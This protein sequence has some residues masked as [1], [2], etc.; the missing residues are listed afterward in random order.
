MKELN[1][2]EKQISNSPTTAAWENLTGSLPLRMTSDYLFKFLLQSDQDVLKAL[3]CAYLDLAPDEVVSICVTNTISLADDPQKKEMI[4]DIKAEMNDDTIINLEMQVI[5]NHDWPERS[6]TYLCR[7]FDNL[8][9]GQAYHRVKGAIHI[10]F[11]DYTLFPEYPEFYSRYR[12]RNE[13]TG[14]LYSS[15]FLISVVNLTK[16]E[17]ATEE[18][19]QAHRD[20]WASF[21]KATS[22]EELKM[23]AQQDTDIAKAVT[24]VHRLF[25]DE[26]FRQQYEAHE[27]RIRQQLDHD[28]WYDNEIKKREAEIADKD[29]EIAD[30]DAEIADK[31]AEIADKDAA[32]ADKDAAIA[33]KDAAIADKDAEIADKDA[34]IADMNAT[35]V[36]M[37]AEIAALK[38][39]LENM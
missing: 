12:L 13:R 35:I 24:M 5:N 29:A 6:I 20:L 2:M 28:Y 22:W 17:L 7:C 23:L 25:E 37:K 11:L 27:D 1:L 31:D 4:L 14:Q 36:D 9:I 8:Q 3:V 32:I 18:D 21:F 33:D 10:G 26:E 34:A 19:I 30:K 15:K 39:Q 16:I 38:A